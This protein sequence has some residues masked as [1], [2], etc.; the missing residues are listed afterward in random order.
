MRPGLGHTL[1]PHAS[2][3]AVAAMTDT[4]RVF[5]CGVTF[6]SSTMAGSRGRVKESRQSWGWSWGG[7]RND[8]KWVE[9]ITVTHGSRGRV[10][11]AEVADVRVEELLLQ[12][13]V[14]Y[15]SG[16]EE[17]GDDKATQ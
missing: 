16:H 6:S 4:I 15:A 5:L 9:Q 2:A 13:F 17:R 8:S 10:E 12:C 7:A 1:V 3:M 11:D 14:V